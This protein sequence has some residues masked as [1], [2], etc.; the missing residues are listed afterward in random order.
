MNFKCIKIIKKKWLIIIFSIL[1]LCSSIFMYKYFSNP[2]RKSINNICSN[3]TSINASCSSAIKNDIID[4]E[5]AL[6]T[7][8]DNQNKLLSEKNK[9]DKLKP[10]AKNLAVQN[11]LQLTLSNNIKLFEQL[12]SILKNP[13]SKDLSKSLNN[14]DSIY[15]ECNKDYAKCTNLCYKI[16]F[17]NAFNRFYKNYVSYTNELIKLTRDI[18]IEA[19]QKKE[20]LKA[21][22]QYLQTFNTLTEDLKPAIDRCKSEKRS[23]DSIAN[24]VDL[25]M[26]SFN[27]LKDDISTLSIPSSAL[28]IFRS[29]TN[30]LDKY[31]D[32]ISCLL[33]TLNNDIC[34]KPYNYDKAYEKYNLMTVDF[35]QFQ[36][37]I[38]NYGQ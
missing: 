25:K 7:L 36:Q 19:T 11:S 4:S 29:F 16:S 18:D 15:S 26:Q 6:A 23:L 13:T 3:I 2:Y 27:K 35:N 38:N 37:L 9:L 14:L 8:S 33:D 12:I 1:I 31:N 32:Y 24:D 21:F 34:G 10:D 17:P 28:E 20:F 22:E 5:I 30:T